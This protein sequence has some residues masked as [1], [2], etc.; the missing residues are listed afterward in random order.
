MITIDGSTRSG[1]VLEM[2]FSWSDCFRNAMW[3]VFYQ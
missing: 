1:S 2:L 3:E